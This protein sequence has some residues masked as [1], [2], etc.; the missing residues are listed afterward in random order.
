[1]RANH[2]RL[3]HHTHT[4]FPHNGEGR[5]LGWAVMEGPHWDWVMVGM[6]PAGP[7]SHWVIGHWLCLS[8]S[9]ILTTNRILGSSIIAPHIAT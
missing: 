1:M 5:A 6:N 7:L 8:G 3:G 2:T 4:E 9:Y